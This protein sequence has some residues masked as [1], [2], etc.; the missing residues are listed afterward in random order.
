MCP[1][2]AKA[3]SVSSS[4]DFSVVRTVQSP[5]SGRPLP[6]H[7]SRTIVG[8]DLK[9][10]PRW[11]QTDRHYGGSWPWRSAHRPVRTGKGR[12]QHRFSRNDVE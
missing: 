4:S 3:V 12:E 5:W 9:L 11:C 7:R 1:S 6:V 8:S 10:T 2:G